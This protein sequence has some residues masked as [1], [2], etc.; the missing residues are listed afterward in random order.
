ME[1]ISAFDVSEFSSL[2]RMC[3]LQWQCREA[4]VSKMAYTIEQSVILV[5]GSQDW[6]VFLERL[7]IVL[8]I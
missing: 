8:R 7:C 1:N 6:S 4:A 3:C 5:K 2:G